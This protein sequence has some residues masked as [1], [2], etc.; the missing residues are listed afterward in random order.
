VDVNWQDSCRNNWI[1]VGV[2]LRTLS[3]LGATASKLAQ[4]KIWK[5]IVMAAVITSPRMVLW[6]SHPRESAL[7]DND[8]Y[9]KF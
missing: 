7:N 2:N 1:L 9:C 6:L 8:L 3:V 5:F 4:L